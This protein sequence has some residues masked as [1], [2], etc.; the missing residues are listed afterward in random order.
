MLLLHDPTRTCAG[1]IST[2]KMTKK[3]PVIFVLA[4]SL[5]ATAFTSADGAPGQSSTVPF[6]PLNSMETRCPTAVADEKRL[7]MRFYSKRP[8]VKAPTDPSLRVALLRMAREDQN[9]RFSLIKHGNSDPKYRRAV[10]TVDA[11]NLQYLRKIFKKYGVPTPKM[12][13]YNGMG[14]ALLL[15]QHQDQDPRWQRQW[16]G[17][18]TQLYKRHEL[19]PEGYALFVD[20]VRVNEGRKQIYG[21]QFFNGGFTMKPTIHPAHLDER[22]KALGLIPEREYECILKTMY[23]PKQARAHHRP[24]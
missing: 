14:A 7:D 11:E 21:S 3:W 24:L 18:V 4:L 13:G 19:S 16:L 2:K 17:A 15:L 8:A 20:R 10:M 1:G 6:V 9:V 5:A 12:V 22:R 23:N